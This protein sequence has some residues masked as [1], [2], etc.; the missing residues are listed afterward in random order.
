[1]LQTEIAPGYQVLALL[2]SGS[3]LDVYDCWSVQR[4]CRCVVKIVRPDRSDEIQAQRRLLREGRLLQ[5]LAHPHI[6]RA[7]DIVERPRPA[8][9][10]ETLSGAT[11]AHL[12]QQHPRG[13]GPADVAALGIQLC[14]A[15]QYLHL[16]GILHLDLKPSNIIVDSGQTKVLD[17]D[18]ARSPG[19]GR[20]EGTRQYMA[21]EQ[22]QRG[23]LTTA[24]DVWAIGTILFQA[25]TGRLPFE[26]ATAPEY[27]QTVCRPQPV[28]RYRRRYPGELAEAID[29]ALDQEACR[30]PTVDQIGESLSAFL[31]C[32]S[33]G[34]RW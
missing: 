2:R 22:V 25:A 20:G 4:R 10:L 29:A 3:V 23:F 27:P 11:L 13:F 9:V 24:T 7:F 32:Q 14:S 30:R 18:I 31:G 17:L 19:R 34:P 5:R 6:V 12:L 16:N 15:T 26:Y 33:D 1:M 8:L 21:P 28:R